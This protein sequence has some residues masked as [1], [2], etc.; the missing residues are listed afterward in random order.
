M[1]KLFKYFITFHT[2]NKLIKEDKEQHINNKYF[3]IQKYQVDKEKDEE[4]VIAGTLIDVGLSEY[5]VEWQR[6]GNMQQSSSILVALIAIIYSVVITFLTMNQPETLYQLTFF[7]KIIY[8]TI[9]IK[10]IFLI[11]SLFLFL[12][13][14]IPGDII[15]LN[16]PLNIYNNFKL[17]SLYERSF[18][19]LNVLDKSLIDLNNYVSSKILKYT[20]CLGF[21]SITLSI[22]V[23]LISAYVISKLG[24]DI[25][26]ISY[27]IAIV[28]LTITVFSI[29]FLKYKKLKKILNE[30]KQSI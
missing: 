20:L 10:T 23:I 25:N 3:D 15:S 22:Q 24:Y 4:K 29:Y 2:I 13:L 28:A 14:L 18:E 1:K 21:S 9:I 19:I 17:K 16:T 6:I 30:K 7:N 11:P 5:E 27:Y 26:L 8:P 12:L